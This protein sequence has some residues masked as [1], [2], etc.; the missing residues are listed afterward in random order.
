MHQQIRTRIRLTETPSGDEALV[1]EAPPGPGAEPAAGATLRGLL[2]LLQPRY[3]LCLVGFSPIDPD[4][5]V[6]AID[7]D[8]DD[9]EATQACADG[10]PP[11]YRAVVE[12]RPTWTVLPNEP[13]ALLKALDELGATSARE[14][15]LG[16]TGDGQAIVHVRT[17]E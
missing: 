14:V 7:H 9:D 10:L 12:E 13:G 8:A 5:F 17:D 3:N 4:T 11:S 1:L 15:F 2:E 6:F 16:Q